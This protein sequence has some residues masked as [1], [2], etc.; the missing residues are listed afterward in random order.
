MVVVAIAGGTGDLG[1][2]FAQELLSQGKH[3][4]LLLSRS[5]PEPERKTLP[6]VVQVNYDDIAQLTKTLEEHAVHT[7]ISAV[8]LQA[9]DGPSRAQVN[10]IKAAGLSST[11]KRFIP[12]EYG[13]LNRPELLS[14]SPS[15]QFFLDAV[16]ALKKTNL[17]YS[18]ILC[19]YLMDYY[20]TPHVKSNLRPFRY[21]LDIETAEAAIPGDGNDLIS[22]IHSTDLAK[23][24]AGAL[25]LDRWSEISV[26]LGDTV[27]FNQILETAQELR[28]I[29][30]KVAYDSLA[31]ME[32]GQVILMSRAM[33]GVDAPKEVLS[34]FYALYG[35]M[36]V[37]GEFDLSKCQ[38][39]N[40]KIPAVKPIK[41]VEMLEMAWKNNS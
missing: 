19:G 1:K 28:G 30:F 7:I 32:K 36:T 20:G 31:D 41:V 38:T 29:N 35:L 22:M 10:L 40:E 13:I 14:L 18:R 8:V 21:G 4:V 23:Y 2:T 25:D 9:D 34:H 3:D 11:T 5:K 37:R 24:V 17:E 27:T 16:T 26:A 33:E 12:S 6:T 15:V 39:I